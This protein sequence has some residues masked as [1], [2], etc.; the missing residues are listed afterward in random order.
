MQQ[1]H[2]GI[3]SQ[4]L[5]SSARVYSRKKKLNA[6]IRLVSECPEFESMLPGLGLLAHLGIIRKILVRYRTLASYFLGQR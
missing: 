4:Y 3:D 1:R 6:E 5:N 2:R